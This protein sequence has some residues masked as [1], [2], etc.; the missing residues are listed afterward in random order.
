MSA[1][2]ETAYPRFKS[3]LSNSDLA[4]YTPTPSELDFARCHSNSQLERL[5]LL[6]HLKII[7]KLGYFIQLSTVP[8]II[9]SHIANHAHLKGISNT[10]LCELD[11]TGAG[12]RLRNLVRKRIDIKT[13]DVNGREVVKSTSEAAAQTMQEL[14]DIINV[15]IEELVCQRFELPAFSALHR[16]ASRAR[17]KSNT[18]IY[19]LIARQLQAGKKK[20][21]DELLIIDPESPQSEWQ[22][23]KREPKKPTNKE[24]RS[25]LEHILWLNSW[26][27]ELPDVGFI[28][29]TKW[30]QFVLEAQSLDAASLKRVKPVKRYALIVILIHAQSRRSMDNSEHIDPENG[31]AS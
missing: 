11:L 31:K 19:G 21:L 26:I 6:I 9:R 3:D 15:V 24:V 1:K 14:A 30:R 13:F 25:Y 12:H 2:H 28:P 4:V 23:I 5:A 10:K 8:T 27:N 29:V 20:A 17:S 22:R 18:S 16:A 7:Q